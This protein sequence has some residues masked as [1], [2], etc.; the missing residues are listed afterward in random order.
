MRGGL[1]VAPHLQRGHAML[2][3]S[4]GENA[5]PWTAPIPGPPWCHSTHFLSRS[6]HCTSSCIMAGGGLP[7]AV[8]LEAAHLTVA[9]HTSWGR[10]VSLM[11][12]IS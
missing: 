2:P 5:A 9:E 4:R 1:H 3:S 6:R 8:V 11:R 10:T 7:S 12:L